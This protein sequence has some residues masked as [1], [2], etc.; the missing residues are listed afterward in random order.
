[1]KKQTLYTFVVL[2]LLGL[3]AGS[4]GAGES[5]TLSSYLA[6]S[7]EGNDTLRAARAQ[8]RIST[9]KNIQAG[10]L[11][12]PK[13]TLQYYLEPVETRTGPQNA[14]I[15]ISQYLPW[16]TKLS[17]QR[18]KSDRELAIAG[19]RLAVVE[20]DVAR[21]VKEAYVEYGFLGRSQQS[22]RDNIEL[23]RY[24]EGVARTRYVSG[25]TSF[26]DVLKIQI[27]LAKSAEKSQAL[28][29]QARP[30][31]VTI[32]K[33]L[34]SE[35]ERAR[36][37]PSH[38]A[39]VELGLEP[40]AIL[41]FAL[42]NTPLLQATRERIGRAK[43]ARELAE[44]D[45][46]PDFTVSLKT[47]FTGDAQYGS[48]PDSGTD[49]VIAGITLNL[50]VFRERRHAKVEQQTAAIASARSLHLGQTRLL[51]AQ[52]ERNLY[53]YREALR[54][55]ALYQEDLLLKVKQQLEVAVNGF[56]S[57]ATN[58]LEL[59]DAEQNQLNFELAESR[60]EADRA[61]AVA[62]L[63]S[64]AGRVLGRWREQ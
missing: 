41:A 4:S 64:L 35:A 25:K 8:Y 39:Q 45:F 24:L 21:Q 33:L 54:K 11:A 61:V 51:S 3:S 18:S 57:G 56:Q 49:P 34:G 32:N 26:F 7:L 23:L 63:E 55:L 2:A 6:Q 53:N 5:P 28:A 16:F 43:V 20:L 31:R 40:E 15:G 12:D 22:L 58:I 46:Y 44:K 29:D 50:P 59:I 60:A 10:V 14:A 27:E 1:M 37:I 52:I 19:A 17:L 9:A 47:I 48:P 36:R 42:S 38:V 13:L 62:R 30:L